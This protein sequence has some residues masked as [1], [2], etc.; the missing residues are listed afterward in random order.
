VSEQW[1]KT[2]EEF[3]L[4]HDSIMARMMA[5]DWPPP[6]PGK[7]FG[8]VDGLRLRV[9]EPATVQEQQDL[10]TGWLHE[11]C[12]LNILVFSA[13]GR[14][15]WR[16]RNH[17]GR[18]HDISHTA[19][20]RLKLIDPACTPPGYALIGDDGFASRALELLI[21]TKAPPS[22]AVPPGLWAKHAAWLT[23]V[24]QAAEWGMQTVQSMWPRITCPLPTNSL[25][26]S[27]ILDTVFMLHNY[28]TN[29]VGRNQTRAIFVEALLRGGM[30]D[31]N[32]VLV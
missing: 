29:T 4:Q 10:Y 17:P 19:F 24:R 3:E 21:D 31:E 2:L 30:M 1:P 26:R 28:M 23:A 20:L 27:E 16:S 5:E 11:L 14:I 15:I 9:K 32:G 6:L 7:W 25:K 22:Y 13:D 8:F 12:C 18:T